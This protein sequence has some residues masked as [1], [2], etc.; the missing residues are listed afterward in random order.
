MSATI[1][2]RDLADTSAISRMCRDSAEPIYITENGHDDMVIM[3]VKTWEEKMW[4]LD[5][6]EKLEESENQ[7]QTGKTLNA[8]TSMQELRAKYG[9]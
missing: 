5:V 8:F 1:P 6:Y 7:I 3:S 2:I 4:L 9:I